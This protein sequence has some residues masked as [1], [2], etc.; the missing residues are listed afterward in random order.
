MSNGSDER[1]AVVAGAVSAPSDLA[2]RVRGLVKRYEGEDVVRGVDFDIARGQIFALLGP[3]GAGKTTTVEILEGFRSR[4]RGE[5]VVLGYDPDRQPG[6]LK[7]RVG[8]VLQS[9]GVEP[10]LSVRETI[11]MYASF[12]P[13]PRPVEEVVNLVGLTS[14]ADDRAIRLSGGQ[15]RRLDVAIAL[16]GD[17]DLLFL[18]EP[19]TGF[20]PSAR[21]DAWSI[22]ENL[23]E[24]GKTVLLTTHY[25]DEAQHLADVVAVIAAGRIVA[26]GSPDT[27]GHREMQQAKVRYRPGGGSAAPTGLSGPVDGDGFCEFATDDAT[28]ALHELTG[29]ALEHGRELE[30]LEVVRPSLE[31]VYLALT[32]PGLAESA[33]PAPPTGAADVV[34]GSS[35]EIAEPAAPALAEEIG[36]TFGARLTRSVALMAS[37][38]RYV[39]K[40]FWRN[41]ARAFFTFAFPLMFLVIFTSLAG[42]FR[43]NVGT[44]TVSSATYYVA[45]MGAYA[46]IN[47]CFDNLAVAVVFQRES[48][49]LKR[50]KGTPLPKISFLAGR[51]VHAMLIG[52]VLVAITAAFGRAFYHVDVPTGLTLLRFLVALVIGS[53]G[54]CALGLAITGVIPNAD[55]AAVIVN[56]VLLPL[57]FLSGIFIPF[58]TTTP[59][60][61]VWV[62]RVFPIR[63]FVGAMQAG[64]LG[65]PF[66]WSD[67]L[68]TAAWGLGG[69]VL[70]YRY[71]SWEPNTH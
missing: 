60:W 19:T 52:V 10:Y 31:D 66:S 54:F 58:T 25:M 57:L 32:A 50:I 14:K 51:I 5:V 22:I 49:I 34:A 36:P 2:I 47:A 55:S 7:S 15:Q 65:T 48:G 59:S 6:A 70:A 71:F 29:W 21:R 56:A 37:Q 33:P 42:S 69:L 35:R 26:T 3:N 24:L 38:V 13:H 43:V 1:G 40:A 17:P 23:A 39:N 41:P 20:D 46:V 45:S 63:H 27:L 8:I 11:R 16:V 53:A 18:D 4:D 9:N 61:I 64:F 28:R 44:R 68:V 12:Y 30:G 62:A 67:V